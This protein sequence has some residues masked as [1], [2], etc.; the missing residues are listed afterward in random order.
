MQN[1]RDKHDTCVQFFILPGRHAEIRSKVVKKNSNPLF[2]ETIKLSLPLESV[3]ERTIGL[4]VIDMNTSNR[5]EILIPLNN[6]D[7]NQIS[8]FVK[9]IGPVTIQRSADSNN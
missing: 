9:K 6:I 4:H 7:F 5:G 2:V 3:R 8:T 1:L